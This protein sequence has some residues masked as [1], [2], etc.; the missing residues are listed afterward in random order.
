MVFLLRE[1]FEESDQ[2]KAGLWR[3]QP[4]LLPPCSPFLAFQLPGNLLEP[5]S[6]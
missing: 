4:P 3:D 2:E 1:D 6:S 5:Q